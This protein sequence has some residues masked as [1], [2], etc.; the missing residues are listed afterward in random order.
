MVMGFD[1]VS[2]LRLKTLHL[3]GKAVSLLLGVSRYGNRTA[4]SLKRKLTGSGVSGNV[5]IRVGIHLLTLRS[6]P[7]TVLSAAWYG[8]LG[9]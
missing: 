8:V 2:T 7:V 9:Q 5:I 1:S 6:G 3:W 4:I